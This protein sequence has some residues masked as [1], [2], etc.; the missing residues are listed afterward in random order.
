M[1]PADSSPD[2]SAVIAC[3]FEEATIAEFHLRLGSA[4]RSA[5]R[6]HE[7]IYVNDGSTDGTWERLRE[8]LG[9]DASV[10]CVLNL[11]RNSGQAA[12]ITAGITQA[13]GQHFL[14][15]DSDLQL[16]PEELPR[17]L[18]KLDAGHDVVT[19]Y[20]AKRKDPL[21]RRLASWV[22]NYIMRSA[23]STPLKDFGCTFKIFDGRLIRAFEFGPNKLFNHVELVSKAGRCAEVPVSHHPRRV[24]KSG[25]TFWKLFEWNM[26]N[27]VNLSSRPFQ[28]MIVATFLL[29]ALL[30]IRIAVDLFLPFTITGEVTHGLLLYSIV[31]SLLLTLG[32]LCLVGE[33]VIRSF[34][35]LQRNPRYIIKDV[36]RR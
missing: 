7:I 30:G 22:A 31:I 2:L 28:Y 15:M 36:L 12:A 29:A 18:E 5:G 21:A 27:V 17:L 10:K 26:E 13:R 24:G 19:G 32:S 25:W 6:S 33:L 35:F 4:L 34:R 3:Y 20:R 1:A 23:S 9:Q 8:I 14:F 11:F 16:D